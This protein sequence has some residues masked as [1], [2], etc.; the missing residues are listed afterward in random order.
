[1][2]RTAVN[3]NGQSPAK[4]EQAYQYLR[5]N[6]QSGRFTPGF[7]LI[8]ATIG[9]EL[10]MSVVP[11][12]EAVRR[13]EA[14]GLVTFEPNVGAFVKIVEENQYVHAINALAVM[15]GAATAQ[16]APYL[17]QEALDQAQAV[18]E[19]MRHTL[20]NLDARTFAVLNHQFHTILMSG[21]AN[22]RLME[23]VDAE[24]TRLGNLQDSGFL[25]VPARA[26]QSV[27]EHAAIIE[28]IRNEAPVGEIEQ[29]VRDHRAAKADAYLDR[30]R[31][32][33]TRGAAAL[34]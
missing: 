14:E 3:A 20:E 7:R 30:S 8:L 26:R 32:E 4:S 16:S 12:R 11:V 19:T 29:V 18:N 31:T 24:W 9:T 21:C 22:D 6:I 1:M 5:D 34:S 28:L 27:R 17:S 23:L 33:E 15:E 10:G 13:L 25:L 2:A